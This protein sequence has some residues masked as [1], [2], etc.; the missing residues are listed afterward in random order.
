MG[1]MDVL[2]RFNKVFGIWKCSQ[3]KKKIRLRSSID[4]EYLCFD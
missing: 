3:E 2:G 4:R 1:H